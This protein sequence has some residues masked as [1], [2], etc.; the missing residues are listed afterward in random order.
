MYTC[1]SQLLGPTAVSTLSAARR[2]RLRLVRPVVVALQRPGAE[3]PRG[4]LAAA[5]GGDEDMEVGGGEI[6]GVW[7]RCLGGCG[8]R[9]CA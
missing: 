7:V 3:V 9:G 8:L 6:R 1:P 5:N 2:Y 4:V